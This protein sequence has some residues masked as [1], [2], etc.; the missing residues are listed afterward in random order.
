MAGVDQLASPLGHLPAGEVARVRE[1]APADA[2]RG[3][4]HGRGDP[5]VRQLERAGE[6]RDPGADDGHGG[7]VAA[8]AHAPRHPERE[9]AG[10][11]AGEQLAAGQPARRG[12]PPGRAPLAQPGERQPGGTGGAILAKQLPQSTEQWRPGH[13]APP[14]NRS[15][16]AARSATP[17]STGPPRAT[18][19]AVPTQPSASVLDPLPSG[20]PPAAPAGPSRPRRRSAALRRGDHRAAGQE[21][22]RDDAQQ[23]PG[24]ARPAR[25][26]PPRRAARRRGAA[27]GQAAPARC[28]R[29]HHEPR[30]RPAGG[31]P[32]PP[33]C[34]RFRERPPGPRL[35]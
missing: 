10:G 12:G 7:I 24:G 17:R 33:S 15:L 5:A 13:G 31:Q 6:P 20:P 26:R 19:R 34:S 22:G 28:R 27:G 4:V 1:H 32:D 11:G 3:L 35:D 2:A 21:G 9:R 18:L 8:G 23:Q 16:Q 25:P 14:W 29:H 30:R